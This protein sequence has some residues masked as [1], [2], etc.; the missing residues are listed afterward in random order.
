M[1][2]TIAVNKAVLNYQDKTDANKIAQ[3]SQRR[4]GTA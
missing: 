1:N 3:T 4:N 2:P